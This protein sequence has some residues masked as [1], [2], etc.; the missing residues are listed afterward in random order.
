MGRKDTPRLCDPVP[1]GCLIGKAVYSCIGPR[2]RTDKPI[3]SKK[4]DGLAKPGPYLR[5]AE[6]ARRLGVSG[7]ALRVYEADGLIR[8]A[9]TAAG[10]RI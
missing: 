4:D 3:R 10:W 9:R 8:A 6:T 2:G 7:K 1:S 5:S